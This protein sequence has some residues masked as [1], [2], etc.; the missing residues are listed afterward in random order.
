M[1]E[2]I[3]PQ[4]HA[5]RHELVPHLCQ[6]ARRLLRVARTRAYVSIC[7]S[8]CS[9][10]GARLGLARSELWPVFF[11]KYCKKTYDNA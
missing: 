11:F 7:F 9:W 5:R 8:V 3:T 2:P 4:T 1:Q 10:E 6:V